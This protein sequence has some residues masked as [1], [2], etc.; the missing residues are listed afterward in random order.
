MIFS[1]NWLKEYIESP[2][3][4]KDLSDVLTMTG[5]EVE[6]VSSSGPS[7][8]GVVTA[9]VL[10]CASHPNAD[11]LQLCEVTD[12]RET[13]SIVCGARN[14]TPGDRV[15]LALDGAEL[16]G[17]V[18]IK[19]SRIRGV[20]SQGMMCSEVELGIKDTSEG[21][22]IL[23]QDIP[24]GRDIN[25]V[26]GLK[27]FMME[28]GVTPNR[29]D[30]LSVRGLSREVSA[31][32][33]A[34]FRDKD[35]T[36]V[37]EGEPVDD[38]ISVSIESGAPCRRYAARVIEGVTIGPS[39]DGLK[40]RLEAHGIRSVNNVV[41]A[42]NY[43][44]LEIGSPL[45]A[46]DLDRI[47][48][49]AIDVRLAGDGESIITIDSREMRLDPSMLVI[50]DDRGPV[51]LAGVMGGKSTEVTDATRNILLEAAWFLP[52]SV[53]R[54]SR[55][56][57]LSTDSSYRFERGVDINGLSRALDLCAVMIKRLAG[58]C[59]AKGT[60]DLYPEEIAQ[61]PIGLRMERVRALLG[62][63]PGKADALDIL[64]RL[65]V[66]AEETHDGVFKAVAPS[67][68]VDIN[69]EIDL[70]E[71]ISRLY[72]Y[73]NIP[74]TLPASAL[75][76][77]FASRAFN[78]KRKVKQVITSIGFIEVINYSFVS[79]NL[80][81]MTG[82]AT[83][84]GVG[85]L[86][87]LTGEQTVMRD[88]LLPS[89][90]DNLR[91]NLLKKNEDLRIFE[92]APIFTPKGKLPDERWKVA[93]LIYGLRWE[94]KWNYAKEWADFFDV[95]GAV[96]RLFDGL[97]MYLPLEVAGVDASDRLFH[98]GKSAALLL[99]GRRCGVFG[100]A[101]PDV[102]QAFDLKRPVYL[103]EADI[104]S[105]V[106]AP[107]MKARYLP[108][109]RFPESARDIAFIVDDRVPYGEI[110]KSIEDLDTKLIEKVELFDVY[111]GG[112]IPS[113][114]RSMA[115]RIVY[116]SAERTLTYEEVESMHSGV[117]KRLAERFGAE[118]RV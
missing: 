118:I 115:I 5:T 100:E 21:I 14:M 91:R 111:C 103:F 15:A 62:V 68:R 42:T 105:I 63:D 65:G 8:S 49:R 96:E 87:P 12:G 50:A 71:E 41:D 24:P 64:K 61:K 73:D 81:S 25:E 79:G 6:S 30:L 35:F 58:G 16:P 69:E 11:R 55:K 46:F 98:P 114:M 29:A 116:R 34:P 40:K 4:P 66:Q 20:E 51:A 78:I 74:V 117:A 43:V 82:A 89:L 102:V 86:N 99:N 39:P 94:Y 97:G 17:G 76:Q 10:G 32:T 13:Y 59:V 83:K 112:N 77:A 57:N 67:W 1:Y 52:S 93:G 27:D 84:E 44:M 37:E 3:A 31:V 54:T 92:L 38:Y 70:I 47:G 9:T 113:G 88:S 53:R 36:L 72:G 56:T 2:L 104:D 108:L 60:I 7:V 33:G 85:I 95:K 107:A 80:F 109:P 19:R 18:R 23:P 45:H 26:L 28:V 48:G 22:M 110:I 75:R 90:L 106:E 101:H